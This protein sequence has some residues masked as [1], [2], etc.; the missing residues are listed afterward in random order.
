MAIKQVGIAAVAATDVITKAQLDTKVGSTTITAIVTLTQTAYTA[1]TPK[2]STT[3]YVIT[4][5]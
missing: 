1:L 4:G 5:P 3:L 2:I